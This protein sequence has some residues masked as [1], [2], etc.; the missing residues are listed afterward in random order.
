[1]TLFKLFHISEVPDID[2][3]VPRETNKEA[4]PHLEDNY[5]WAVSGEMLQNYLF[6][7][8]C[9][10]VCWMVGPRTSR[11]DRLQFQSVGNQRAIIGVE[12][13]WEKDI[14]S[15][16]LFRYE[17]DPAPFYAVDYC[18]G[19]Y[20]SNTAQSPIAVDEITR[21]VEMAEDLGVRLEFHNDI[22]PLRLR[23]AESTYR[24]SIIRRKFIGTKKGP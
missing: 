3:F 8:N 2:I 15:C 17:F 10:R 6:P 20:I 4:W 13:A 16:R 5:V 18:A 9:P 23:I 19:Y 14:K 21:P 7:R 12:K 24:Y 22:N 11:D 1:M